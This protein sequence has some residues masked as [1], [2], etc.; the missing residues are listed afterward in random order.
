MKIESVEVGHRVVA[1][2]RE[3]PDATLETVKAAFTYPNPAYFQAAQRARGRYEPKE[4]KTLSTI[5]IDRSRTGS[6]RLT[7]SRGAGIRL[8]SMLSKDFVAPPTIE[9]LESEA[10]ESGALTLGAPE[11]RA[12]FP[13]LRFEVAL[14]DYQRQQVEAGTRHR[15]ALWRGPP[16][17]GKTEATFGLVHALR[18]PTI[19]VV[20]AE[21]IFSQWV[22]R[23]QTTF[24]L[25][26]EQVGVLQGSDR[27][28][29]PITIAMQQTL[30]N[31]VDKLADKFG[32]FVAD[33]V[34]RH[35]AE[36][37][38]GVTD[39]FTAAH[40]LGVS[41]DERRA[42]G[43]E[44]LIYDLFGPVR[45]QV[46]RETLTAEGSLVEATIVI[47]PT[48]FTNDWY[49]RIHP[50]M[51]ADAQVQRRLMSEIVQDPGRNELIRGLVRR[52]FEE[53]LPTM[54]LTHRIEH[55]HQ[56]RAD[57]VATAGQAGLMIGGSNV[58]TKRQFE[59]ARRQ[60]IEGQL[61]VGVG[62]YQAVGVG[63]DLPALARGI[64]ATPCANSKT[65]RMQFHQF[66]GRFERPHPE[67]RGA[68]IYYLWD[69][70]IHGDGPVRNIASWKRDVVVERPDGS[71]VS[72]RQFLKDRRVAEEQGDI[73]K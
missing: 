57:A 40:R 63:F 36:T 30:Q 67:K 58:E 14:R 70:N 42:D 17:S 43:K 28:I 51:K 64:F 34:Q 68:E 18:I 50:R 59:H 32:L 66:C 12:A 54:V 35:G 10:L 6:V 15:L 47:V 22:R 38:F 41:A 53:S 31:H 52:C 4:P 11:L 55:A 29:R 19:V 62:T 26:E 1:V 73:F 65:G 33:E 60:M 24:G 27:R 39:R 69:R 13:S 46:D 44:F 9:A 8:L 5:V 37:F 56:L 25:S 61:R 45:H 3:I 23:C 21:K 16:G 7:V 20:P 49:S 71:R 72:A 2:V 48:E